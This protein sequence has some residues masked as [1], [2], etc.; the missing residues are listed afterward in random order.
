MLGVIA[1]GEPNTLDA[2]DVSGMENIYFFCTYHSWTKSLNTPAWF[3]FK[4]IKR[5]KNE[6]KT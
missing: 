6:A 1:M 5:K 3:S 4:N 2:C